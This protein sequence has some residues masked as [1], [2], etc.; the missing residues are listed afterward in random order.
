M[1]YDH[2]AT[3]LDELAAA[4]HRIATVM[5][6]RE[7]RV[8]GQSVPTASLDEMVK[9]MLSAVLVHHR[10][11][12][13]FYASDC[14]PVTRTNSEAQALLRYAVRNGWVATQDEKLYWLTIGGTSVLIA[15]EAE[16]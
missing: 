16:R 3:A 6:A 5:E 14:F 7:Q 2:V 1:K 12:D 4:Q 9:T 8:A 11:Y 15:W 13:P 10:D